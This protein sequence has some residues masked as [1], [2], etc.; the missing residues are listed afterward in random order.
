MRE[1]ELYKVD[2]S[3]AFDKRGSKYVIT[4]DYYGSIMPHKEAEEDQP[5]FCKDCKHMG[6]GGVSCVCHKFILKRHLVSGETEFVPCVA[7]RY[8]ESKCGE[9]AKSF[10]GRLSL[11][12]SVVAWWLGDKR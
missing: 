10:E 11:W 9:S 7:A 2:D 3:T 12:E 5:R 6:C 8:D 4:T 1:E